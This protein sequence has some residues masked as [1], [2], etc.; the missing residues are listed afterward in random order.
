MI[1]KLII[2]IFAMSPFFDPVGHNYA[3]RWIGIFSML[4]LLLYRS[5]NLLKAPIKRSLLYPS[6]FFL[7]SWPFHGLL[8]SFIN[9]GLIL[10]NFIDTSYLAFSVLFL[11]SIPII[12]LGKYFNIYYQYILAISI[13]FSV[14]S[15]ILYFNVLSVN[16]TAGLSN[17]LTSKSV[18]I[19]AEREYFGIKIKMI[20]FLSAP[21]FFIPLSHFL[22]KSIDNRIYLLVSFLPLL[23]L[24]GTGTR[25]HIFLGLAYSL[26]MLPNIILRNLSYSRLAILKFFLI[27]P[28][29]IG[30]IFD[31][32]LNSISE[33]IS[34]PKRVELLSFYFNTFD[35]ASNFLFG[36]G[37]N[38]IIW[39]DQLLYWTEGA[40]KTELT[41]LEYIRVFGVISFVI[42]LMV[43]IY[44][45]MALKNKGNTVE[46]HLLL[47]I[48]INA[49]INPYLIS[50][51]GIVPIIICLGRL[52]ANRVKY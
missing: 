52:Y 24:I 3:I 42:L 10:D 17:Y 5:H 51:N 48:L 39:D 6:I 28:L 40:S 1:D 45:L 37:F 41:Y 27:I 4:L 36:Q 35:N 32:D 7:F 26:W 33:T 11:A 46:F 12:L 50:I 22:N 38:A 16:Q 21:L 19:I 49:S 23:A 2:F 43:F 29:I 30:L 9:G 34:S 20:Y 25:S 14:L 44:I 8:M 47:L 13:I 18:A 31:I 15:V